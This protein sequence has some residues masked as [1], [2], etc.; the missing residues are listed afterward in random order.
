MQIKY[1]PDIVEMLKA[2]GMTDAQ[3]RQSEVKATQASNQIFKA[4][5]TGGAKSENPIQRKFT[6]GDLTPLG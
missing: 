4:E 1:D 2:S 5:G 3:I 6:P